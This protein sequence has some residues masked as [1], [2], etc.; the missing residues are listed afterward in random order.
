MLNIFVMLMLDNTLSQPT[1][2]RESDA[3][4]TGASSKKEKCMES[5]PTFIRG[6]RRKNRK[7]RGLQTLSVKGLGVV[8]THRKGI[9]TPRVR[10]KGR[11]PLIEC[12]NMTL[13]C[14]IFPFTFFM[15]FYAFCIFHLFV[16]EKGV[17][18]APTYSSIVIRKSYLRSSSRT[19]RWLSCF[20][21]FARY[22]FYLN[23]RPF[24]ALDH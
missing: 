16:V 8:F 20:I 18:L 14:F 4:L 6:K 24:K 13:N 17:S 2:R 1:L 9:S 11:Q 23:K 22:I 5:P 15:S 19:K 21:F 10:H 3:R 7:R 12:A